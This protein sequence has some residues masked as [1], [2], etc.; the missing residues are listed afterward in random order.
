MNTELAKQAQILLKMISHSIHG[1]WPLFPDLDYP[2]AQAQPK[3]PLASTPS[4]A[5]ATTLLP[6]RATRPRLP[7]RPAFSAIRMEC[8]RLLKSLDSLTAREA[9]Q[10]LGLDEALVQ[11]QFSELHGLRL[12]NKG[13]ARK[14][15]EQVLPL[16][17]LNPSHPVLELL[18]GPAPGQNGPSKP[19][20]C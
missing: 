3:R 7:R 10:R 11:S 19:S 5:R 14:V 4:A 1:P 9:A 20:A 8:L 17:H 16:F 2:A 12:I 15:D 18:L 13:G 6:L